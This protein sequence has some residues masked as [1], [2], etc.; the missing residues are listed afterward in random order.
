M[1][2]QQL[3]TRGGVAGKLSSFKMFANPPSLPISAPHTAR[4]SVPH[5]SG[6]AHDEAGR[7]RKEK[8]NS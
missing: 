3:H 4:V 1:A 5:L 2:S 6:A 7:G 8:E